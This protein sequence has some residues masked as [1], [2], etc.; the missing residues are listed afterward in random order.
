MSYASVAAHNAPPAALQ[1][2]P[3]PSLLTT[4]PPTQD[5][6]AD[7]AA[8]LNVVA[9]D[10][11]Q[12]P[13][14]TTSTASVPIQ[15][16]PQPISGGVPLDTSGSGPAYGH[17]AADAAKR[18]VHEAEEE[19]VHSWNVAKRYLLRPGVAGGLLGVVNLGLLSWAGYALYTKPG[20]RRDTRFLASATAAALTILGAEGYAA[21]RYRETPAGREEEHKAR[22]EGAALYRAARENLLRP[23]VL[24]GILGFLNTAILGTVGY[25]AYK[26]WDAPRW[27]R[28]IVSAVSVGILTLW[29]GEGYIAE[30][31]RK[32][33]RQ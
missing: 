28:R 29:T 19:G 6:I 15:P 3:D 9:P 1:P 14:T 7:D 18:Y 11:K 24:G 10:F 26:H 12:H 4:E 22:A 21:E 30:Q 17:R 31:Y 23:G 2:K 20:L 5:N 32:K 25:F 33:D 13:E 8:K 27:D 16:L